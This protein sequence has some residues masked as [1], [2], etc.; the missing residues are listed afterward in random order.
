MP[1]ESRSS[2]PTGR[3]L[4]CG[5]GL[6]GLAA[7]VS[8]AEAGARVTLIDKASRSGGSTALSG[9]ILWTYADYDRLRQAVPHGNAMLQWLVHDGIRPAAAWL[10]ALGVRAGPEASF[11]TI[12]RGWQIE[13]EQ[14]LQTLA[15]RLAERGGEVQHNCA[16]DTLTMEDGRV[17][18]ARCIGAEGALELEAS[19]VV[20]ATGGFQG[21]AELVTRYIV[22]DASRLALRASPWSTGDGLLAATAIGAACS[23]ALDKFYGHALCV[24]P[25]LDRTTGAIDFTALSQYYGP[26]AVA[27][28]IE[29]R[30]FCDESDAPEEILNYRLAQQP[31]ARGWYVLDEAMLAMRPMPGM[32]FVNSVIVG[33][34]RSAGARVVSGDSIDA[35]CEGLARDGVPAGAARIEL[36]RFNAAMQNG[37]EDE[38]APARCANRRALVPP[39]HAVPVQAAITFTMGGLAIDE[40]ARVLRRAASSAVGRRVPAERGHVELGDAPVDLGHYYRESVVPGLYAAGCDV[41]NVHHR[42]YLG[43]LAAGLVIGRIAGKQAAGFAARRHAGHHG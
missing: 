15:A 1:A 30:R 22:R 32:D 25:N 19:A 27:L 33:R 16:L 28:N 37:L 38:L 39:L 31:E 40:H 8:A 42:G 34:A 20:L 13:P 3:V 10:F 4:V 14:A 6:A 41:G 43:G 29:G 17:V 23:P 11:F 24:V 5:S 7:A 2:A 35:L 36:Q 21:N 18:G 9:G 26:A 12:G